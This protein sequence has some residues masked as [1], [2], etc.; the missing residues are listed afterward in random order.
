[1]A[2]LALRG[3]Q[4]EMPVKLRTYDRGDASRQQRLETI[5]GRMSERLIR[6]FESCDHVP[7]D[8]WFT[9]HLYHKAP[10]LIGPHVAAALNVPY[11]VAEA[12]VAGKQRNG[13]W[14]RG[15][16]SNVQSLR[17]ASLVIGLNPH[18]KEGVLPCLS[19]TTQY[20]DVPPFID[21]RPF[22]DAARNRAA[23]RAELA[24]RLKISTDRPWLIAVAMMRQ[25]Q[26]LASYRVL[27]SALATVQEPW[28]LLL[29]GDGPAA[30]T[31]RDA[32]RT[33]GDRVVHYGVALEHETPTL[34]AAC[35][36]YVWPSIKEAWGMA[37]IEAQAAGL[38]V[39]AGRSGGVTNVVAEGGSGLL[40]DEGDIAGLAANIRHLLE[41]P[42]TRSKM[43]AAALW[44]VRHRHDLD[45]G[46]EALESAL[47]KV[48]DA[49]ADQLG[50][51]SE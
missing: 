26:K 19:A 39:V 44:N 27:A 15:Y 31:V 43:R 32:F 4:I 30:A 20:V 45:A 5:G 11:V 47:Q 50:R 33:F 21:S 8:L 1:M 42:A 34:Y 36:I 3:H 2:A 12:S 13:K 38:A 48:L 25:D 24:D 23:I 17:S 16:E 6:R 7:I 35:D 9:Y 29:V 37:L 18:D 51:E 40:S 46:A 49:S 14:S 41:N 28:Q 22:A 10:D